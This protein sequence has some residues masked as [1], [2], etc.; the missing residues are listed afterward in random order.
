MFD[1][2]K[3]KKQKEKE[4]PGR[5]ILRAENPTFKPIELKEEDMKDIRIIG[6]AV[7]FCSK[8]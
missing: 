3:L 6:K 2:F 8:L 5:I 4:I 1:N 7:G